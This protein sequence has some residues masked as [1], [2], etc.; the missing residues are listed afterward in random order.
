MKL[1]IQQLFLFFVLSS[2]LLHAESFSIEGRVVEVLP[3]EKSFKVELAESAIADIPAGETY[4]FRVGS[5]DLEI[6]YLERLIK[7][8]A[9][10]YNNAWHL[11]RVF[12]LDGIGAKALKDVNRQ[13]HNQVASM[14]R[15]EY[16]REGSYL[17]NF[18]MIDQNGNFLQ[19][20]ELRGKAFVL[21]FIFTRC[22]V[23]TMCPASTTRMSE[24]Q[25]ASREAGLE[26]VDFVTITFDPEFDS[27]GILRNYAKNYGLENDNFHLLTATQETVDDLLRLFGILTVEEDG[28]INH[29]MATLLVDANGRIAFRKE[30][31]TWTVDEF[32]KEIEA[33]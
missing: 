6:G 22:K 33:L 1:L 11:E 14:T 4:D 19:I 9:V 15:R 10:Y 5:G 20:R 12:P 21:N 24:L 25:D 26:N 3:D 27:P 17:P 32:L 31:S 29:T 30:G 13:L 8:Q 16:L 28:T 7:A 2:A 23:A 18:A